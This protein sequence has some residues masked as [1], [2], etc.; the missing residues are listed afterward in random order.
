MISRIKRV[1]WY[2]L[3]TTWTRRCRLIHT[4][5][6][7]PSTASLSCAEDQEGAKVW[8]RSFEEAKTVPKSLVEL[9]FSRSSGPG[10]QNVNKVETK[11]SARCHIDAPWIPMWARESLV[12]TPYY[13]KTSH[14]LLVS[15]TVSR[16]QARNIDDSLSKMHTIVMDAAKNF[17]TSEPS[18]KQRQRVANLEKAHDSR[19]RLEKNKRSA[20]KKMRS[21]KG[22][23]E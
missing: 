16:S 7:P 17:I 23:S 21:N 3:T 4:L 2:A 22:W 11:V 6:I 13:V 12:M 15:S 14:S 18:A 10:G 1:S 20:V 19:R 9:T 5:P 8:L